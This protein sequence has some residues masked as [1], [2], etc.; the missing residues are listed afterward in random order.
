MAI[1]K[2]KNDC[3]C[4][5]PVRNSDKKGG[6]KNVIVKKTIKKRA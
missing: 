5:K 4:G 3:G 6:K 2:G 1:R